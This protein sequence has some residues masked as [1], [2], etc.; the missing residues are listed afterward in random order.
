M[1]GNRTLPA[2]LLVFAALP[3]L[4]CGPAAADP[5]APQPAPAATRGPDVVRPTVQLRNGEKRGS[6][7][8]IVSVP[9]TTLILT[10]AHVLKGGTE[11]TVE[12][13]RHNLGLAS[14]SAG[15]TEGGGWPR[16]VKGAVVA[17]DPAGDV[18]LVKVTGMVALPHVARFDPD[19]A[20][21]RPGELVT[22]VGIDRGLHLTRW[23]TG[24]QG[25]AVIDIHQ[26]GDGAR[27]FTVVTRFPELGHSGGGL[28]RADGTIVGV[29]TGQL[30]IRPGTPKVGVFASFES[31]RR[32]LEGYGL[33]KPRP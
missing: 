20:S 10:A 30:S 8:V 21:P 28:F 26:G 24:V 18:A 13:H 33:L 29:C 17:R 7:T 22:S 32:L 31:V 4:A 6:G 16:L 9:G 11:A 23:Q 3:A 1:N 25:T 14:T 12:L 15:L 5:P 19:A 2:R 27:P